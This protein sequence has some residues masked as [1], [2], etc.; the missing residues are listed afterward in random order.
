MPTVAELCLGEEFGPLQEIAHLEG[1]QLDQRDSLS[2]VLGLPA[3]DGSCFWLLCRCENYPGAPPAW[4]WYN[5]ETHAIDQPRD[6]PTGG[7]FLHSSGVICAPWNLLA[8]KS[9]DARG[10]HSDWTIGDWRANPMTGGCKTFS[11]MALRIA[12]E[13]KA[14]SFA[15]RRG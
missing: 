8:Y 15:G 4:H 12:F 2:F 5:P 10:P 7:N 1:W 14:P 3:R 11:A 6:T 13:L 9:A